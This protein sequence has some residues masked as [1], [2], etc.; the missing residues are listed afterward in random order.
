MVTV[1]RRFVTLV[2]A[3][4][5]A[6]C[7][8]WLFAGPQAQPARVP[9]AVPAIDTDDI[10][11]V[12][13]GP[14]RP[15]S[16]RLGDRRD[17]RPARPL[18]QERRHR[19]SR[20]L[21][22]PRSAAR[23][24]TAC[25]RAATAWSTA[26][27]RRREPGQ[28]RQHHREDRAER[29][30]GRAVLPGHLLVLDAEDSG[31]RSSSAARAASPRNMTQTALAQRD[32]EHRLHRLPSARPAVHAHDSGGARHVRIRRRGVEAP[33]AVGPGRRSMMFGQLTGLGDASFAQLR[34]LD[35]SHREGRAAVRQAASARRASSATSS[36]RCA[37]G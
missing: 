35:R 28:Q 8:P 25:G 6:A 7:A 23:A 37:T 21:R 19:R 24:A 14:E 11:G 12:V 10:G 18:H 15:R 4:G 13:T 30:R 17:A 29:G 1:G 26:R 2:L 36:S 5:L 31:R 33:R 3:M 27:R 22:R 20:P 9:P 34:R 16:R 32:E